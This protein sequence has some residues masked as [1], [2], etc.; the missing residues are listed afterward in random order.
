[1][2][3]S[4]SVLYVYMLVCLFC[5]RYPRLYVC[6]CYRGGD[7]K[8]EPPENEDEVHEGVGLNI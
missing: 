8:G 7:V 4:L 5:I 2:N 6:G 3:S 1:M